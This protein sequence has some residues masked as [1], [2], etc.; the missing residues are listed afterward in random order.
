MHLIEKG[1]VMNSKKKIEQYLQNAPKSA[2]PEGLL[3]RLQKG[4]ALTTDHKRSVVRRWFVPDDGSVSIRRM[5]IAAM[6]TV[7][8]IL[9]L[10]YGAT[11]AVKYIITTFETRFEYPKD[12]TTYSFTT[13]ISASDNIQ[14]K[15]DARKD[16]AEFY[17]LYKQ[18]KAKEVNPGI[19]KATLSNGEEFGYGGDPEQLGLSDVERKEQLKKQF[20]E[21]NE[22]KKAG[23]YEK[24]YKPEH[25]YVIDGIKYR[26]FEA[27]YTLSDGR[28]VKT[29]DSE[30]AED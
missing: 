26:Y 9:P 20:D 4:I 18:G 22:L 1:N 23:Q 11:K 29:G 19:W 21:I 28:V 25:D 17:Q 2:A 8:A 30:P 13:L 14:N 27:T 12:N 10:S 15:E 5:A 7:A 3:E 16:E 6:L 24:A